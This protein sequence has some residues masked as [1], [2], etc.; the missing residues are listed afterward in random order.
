MNLKTT[1]GALKTLLLTFASIIST[2]VKELSENLHNKAVR[3]IKKLKLPSKAKFFTTQ[4]DL[5]E[6]IGEIKKDPPEVIIANVATGG[7]E[8]LILEVFE[9]TKVP[10]ILIANDK[11]NSLAAALEIRAYLRE[12]GIDIPLLFHVDFEKN[13]L[14]SLI[15]TLK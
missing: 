7:V 1:T 15:R 12:R 3:L 13:F 4:E 9:R 14:K 2:D 6:L 11:S 8:N 5:G 10:M